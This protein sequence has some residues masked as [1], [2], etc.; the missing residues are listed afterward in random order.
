MISN[1]NLK[2]YTNIKNKKGIDKINALFIFNILD[3]HSI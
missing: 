2:I 1:V 3:Y